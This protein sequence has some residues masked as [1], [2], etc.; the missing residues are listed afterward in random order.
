VS[1]LVRG[2]RS[3]GRNRTRTLLVGVL[4]AVS[5]AVFVALT[6]AGA[7]TR[8]EA[9]RLRSETATLISVSP[10]GQPAGGGSF[11]GLPERL[12]ERLSEVRGVERV[13]RYV[14][15]QFFDNRVGLTG[16]VVNG[17]EPGAPLRLAAM[18][19]FTGSPQIVEGR[20]LRG[21]DAGTTNAVVGSEFAKRYEVEVGDR[22][23]LPARV[24]R[25]R[26]GPAEVGDLRARV[27]GVYRTGVVF[28]DNQVFVP[29]GLA[30]RV[31]AY[32]DDVT[33]LYVT[34]VSADRV[35]AVTAALRSAGGD[36]VDVLA[37]EANAQR[38]AGSLAAVTT[39]AR[40]GALI[41]AVA[42]GAIVLLTMILVTRER[43]REIGVLKAIGASNRAV[44]GQ[45]AGEALA[46]ALLGGVAGLVLAAVGGAA[47]ADAL[48]GT[49]EAGAQPA[50]SPGTLAAGL[51]LAL[52]FGLLGALYTVARAVRLRPVEAIRSS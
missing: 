10:A 4:L 39:N 44:A 43:R 46:L 15:V 29:L 35:E 30:Q 5:V 12:A 16:G 9:E 1:D 42:G 51:A 21:G 22:L 47:L 45:F 27:V 13:E 2:L 34:A 23:A 40:L 8:A 26:R 48:V 41:A 37:Q 3:V 28:G 50:P 20:R 36:R 11:V 32:G 52:G 14:R 18:G 25:G 7:A 24:L 17:V 33:Q 38:V 31:L 49:T 6:Q 19:G